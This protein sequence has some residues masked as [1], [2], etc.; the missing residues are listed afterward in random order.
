MSKATLIHDVKQV[1]ANFQLLGDYVDAAPYGSGHINDTYAV[2]Y[3]QGG[4]RLRYLVQRINH[5]IF[6]TPVALMENISR[7]TDH[8][9]RKL[10]ESH[11]EEASRRAMTVIRSNDNAPL[12]Q[13]A[14]GNYWRVYIF[15]EGATGH[16]IIQTEKQAYEAAKAFGAFQD[17]MSDLPGKRLNETIPDFHN[18]PKR[19]EAFEEALRADKF[20]RAKNASEEI[21]FAVA[22][23]TLAYKLLE[24]HKAGEIPERAT[25]NDTKLN[26]VL[27]DDK[28]D[29]AFCVIDLDTLMPGLALYD[30]GDLVR[31]STSPVT[32]DEQDLS[33]VFLQ[34]NMFTALAKGYL[35]SAGG[36]L[37]QTEIDYMAYSGKLITFETGLR[38]ITDYLQGDI[39]FKTH[40]DGHNIDRCR[41][42]F[43]LV[44]SIEDQEN[45]LNQIVKTISAS[46]KKGANT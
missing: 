21:S 44:A 31:T 36:F 32:E 45:D 34:K 35:E 38:F 18:T 15:V 22:R 4:K 39:Y 12:F 9:Q 11:V 8:A 7:V 16:D 33:K 40:R 19:Y 29:E 17:L 46:M 26:N 41:T 13:D 43:K 27:I 20:D 6:K 42:Q 30:F 3:D 10:A 28:T 14:D 2:N 23:K 24:L 1:C 5:T 25:H 37:N